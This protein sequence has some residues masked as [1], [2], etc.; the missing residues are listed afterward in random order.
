MYR[1]FRQIEEV[2]LQRSSKKTVALAGSQ[3]DDVLSAVVGAR[4]KNMIEAILIGDKKKTE[5]LL[6]QM[7]EETGDYTFVSCE[8]ERETARMACQLV[9]EGKADFPMKGLIQTSSFMK[10][11]LDKESFAFIPEKGILSQATLLEFEG[12]MMI[13]TDCAVN[14]SPDYTTKIKILDN[15]VGLAKKIGIERS[16]AAV[17][18]PVEVVNPN[19]QST[20][21]AAMLSIASRR[22]QI[23]DCIVDGPLAMDNAL[24]KEAAL[25]KGIESDVAGEADIFLMPDLCTGNVLTKALVHFTKG[26]PSAGLL[27]GTTIPVVMTSRTDTPENKYYAILASIL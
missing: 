1:S 26:I 21:D 9:K 16:K 19:M 5:T 11:V 17:L 10:A 25:H 13:I 2:V 12:R 24:S 14:I 7:G 22:G 15:A 6:K 18:A 23:K 27:L 8:G 3:D 20:I 4:R